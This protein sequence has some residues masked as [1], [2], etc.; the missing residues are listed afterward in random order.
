MEISFINVSFRDKRKIKFCTL[1]VFRPFPELVLNGIQLQVIHMSNRHIWWWRILVPIKVNPFVLCA[2][3]RTVTPGYI[4]LYAHSFG[5]PPGTIVSP[6]SR[7]L[8]TPRS[9]SQPSPLPEFFPYL[10]IASWWSSHSLVWQR[11]SDLLFTF[12]FP[13]N[14]R[15]QCLSDTLPWSPVG[16]AVG[17]HYCNMVL[18]WTAQLLTVY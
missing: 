17:R 5:S 6:P 3:W 14:S 1:F 13:P 18:S 2:Y 15:F 4:L 7:G 10:P 11:R 9:P 12:S 8:S 16:A